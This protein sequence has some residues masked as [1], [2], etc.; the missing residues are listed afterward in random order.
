[1]SVFGDRVVRVEDPKLLTVGGTYVTDLRIPELDGAV[2]VTYVRSTIAHADLTSIEVD[3]ART[4][5][6]VVGVFTAA[7]IDLADLPAGHPCSRRHD[8][9]VPRPRQGPLRRRTPRRDPHE[10]PEQGVDAAELVWADVE[11]LPAVVEPSAAA[12]DEV[13]LHDAAGTNV[14]V[15]LAFGRSDDLFEGCEVVVT[16]DVRNQR[17]A[18]C[19]SSPARPPRRGSAVGWSSGRAPSTRTGCATPSSACTASTRRRCT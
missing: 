16:Q 5:P 9:A 8:A 17:V 19:R 3:E 12:T 10:R 18:P 13:V 2:H 14:V 15:D 7:D 6:G 1:M 11:P 4:A